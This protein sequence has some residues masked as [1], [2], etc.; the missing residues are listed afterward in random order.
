MATTDG[1]LGT[2]YGD[3]YLSNVPVSS[4]TPGKQPPKPSIFRRFRELRRGSSLTSTEGTENL[5]STDSDVGATPTTITPK[6]QPAQPASTGSL[7]MRFRRTSTKSLSAKESVTVQDDTK[8]ASPGGTVDDRSVAG[9]KK[10][11]DHED[12]HR[13]DTKNNA[14]STLE[15]DEF[16]GNDIV[17]SVELQSSK[18]SIADGKDSSAEDIV[19]GGTRID[20]ASTDE[21][22]NLDVVVGTV[23]PSGNKLSNSGGENS[24]GNTHDGGDISDVP[25]STDES[26]VPVAICQQSLSIENAAHNSQHE[27]TEIDTAVMSDVRAST[28]S[29][30]PSVAT[31]VAPSRD[32]DGDTDRLSMASR[33][34]ATE[35]TPTTDA[36][37]TAVKAPNTDTEKD[38]VDAGGH[39]DS[40]DNTA[41]DDADGVP[42]PTT[43]GTKIRGFYSRIRRKSN[44]GHRRTN[45]A[46]T[47]ML[48][49]ARTHAIDA[50]LQEA[51]CEQ[52]E[53]HTDEAAGD[54]DAANVTATSGTKGATDGSANGQENDG[55]SVADSS[56]PTPGKDPGQ[57]G[58]DGDVALVPDTCLA[59]QATDS[60]GS[61]GEAPSGNTVAEHRVS[62]PRVRK[63]THRRS[64]SHTS[65][66]TATSHGH[67]P[68]PDKGF[69]WLT[70]E[71]G[72]LRQHVTS[73][74]RSVSPGD[75]VRFLQGLLAIETVSS[76]RGQ[77]ETFLQGFREV[78]PLD[79]S[80][81]EGSAATADVRIEHASDQTSLQI[82][83]SIM[84]RITQKDEA[85][86]PKIK[87][88]LH[89]RSKSD[90][91]DQLLLV[92]H[93]GDDSD[94]AGLLTDH[95]AC[96][97]VIRGSLEFDSLAL[98][99]PMRPPP[100]VAYTSTAERAQMLEEDDDKDA[101]IARSVSLP[102]GSFASDTSPPVTADLWE[103]S[104]GDDLALDG[105]FFRD[106]P[107]EDD[108]VVPTS[109]PRSHS[110][111]KM[112]SSTKATRHFLPSAEGALAKQS[113][114]DVGDV[115]SGFVVPQYELGNGTA[116]KG[117]DA[118]LA[119]TSDWSE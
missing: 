9:A 85:K 10:D 37:N 56:N 33:E 95:E 50:T 31:E 93:M 48:V 112:L 57:V 64:A 41:D 21:S 60:S 20:A 15:S 109:L 32:V 40:G 11:A 101:P 53:A 36:S 71:H 61:E 84:D 16:V 38:V 42:E 47:S 80:V 114:L 67:S 49:F 83:E 66:I 65:I 92:E 82:M 99:P 39:A 113:D 110:D 54:G 90:V 117:E 12:D 26:S 22:S 52:K 107:P 19:G 91:L 76:R 6:P 105:E 98:T 77:I 111:P 25:C 24:P 30:T 55:L 103:D 46:P 97:D 72:V 96:D 8:S 59:E 13:K 23:A 116:T 3:V 62:I 81:M 115:D 104:F 7:F 102:F 73:K 45:S 51:A 2:V 75:A 74:A 29:T 78:T 100:P 34:P 17:S 79:D 118:T 18:S 44:F 28:D 68:G 43:F 1:D 35:S 70:G 89:R 14:G 63:Y 106:D 86:T 108:G 5:S 58:G 94:L 88:I 87:R 4:D 27:A 119:P 69:E